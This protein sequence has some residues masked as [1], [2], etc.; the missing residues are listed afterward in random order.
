[1]IEHT[2]E[3]S[4]TICLAAVG[5]MVMYLQKRKRN[6]TCKNILFYRSSMY[7]GRSEIRLGY[8]MLKIW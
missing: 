3:G 4:L 7:E 1:M 8:I 2:F 6:L 5:I